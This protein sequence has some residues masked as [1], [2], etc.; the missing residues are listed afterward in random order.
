MSGDEAIGAVI[1]ALTA[2][3]VPYM[4]V[5]S[6]SSNLYGVPRATEDADIVIHLGASSI[7]NLAQRL[8]PSLRFDPHLSFETVTFTSRNQIKVVDSEFT[9]EVTG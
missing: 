5:G 6:F 2:L 9:I 7:S 1:D 8:G 4:V 3:G